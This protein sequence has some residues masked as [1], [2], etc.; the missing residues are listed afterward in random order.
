MTNL[1]LFCYFILKHVI[2]RVDICPVTWI[3]LQYVI[4][5]FPDHTHFLNQRDH[6]CRERLEVK[7]CLYEP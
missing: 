4:V 7:S 5:V 3:G 2:F 6:F 1:D